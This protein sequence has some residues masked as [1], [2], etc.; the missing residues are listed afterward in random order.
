MAFISAALCRQVQSA[1]K[2]Q[3]FSANCSS[4]IS[5]GLLCIREYSKKKMGLPRVFFD[6]AADDAPIGR[7]IMEVSIKDIC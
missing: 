7:I 1:I 4:L 6:M 2:T 3:Q 5:G